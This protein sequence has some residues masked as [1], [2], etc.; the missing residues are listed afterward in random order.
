[1]VSSSNRRIDTSITSGRLYH[2]LT[3][4]SGRSPDPNV[5][6]YAIIAIPEVGGLHHR[7][8]R[9]AA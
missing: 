1:M 4:P 5:E 8:E 9:Q 3:K 7:Y 6:H 2:T